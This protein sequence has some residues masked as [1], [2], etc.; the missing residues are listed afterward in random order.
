ML[1]Y[2]NE[3][4]KLI[5]VFKGRMDTITSMKL[6][7]DLDVATRSAKKSV[8]FDLAGVDY[9]SSSFIR[10][11]LAAAKVVGNG[12]FSVVNAT[13][14]IKNIMRTAGLESFLS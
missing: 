8:V 7:N 5:C 4:D 10:L 11:C 12:N 9:V 1:E 13:D 2:K 3:T 14:F 6:E